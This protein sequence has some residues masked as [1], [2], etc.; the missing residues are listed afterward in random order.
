MAINVNLYIKKDTLV[1]RL[2]GEMDQLTSD[3]LRLKLSELIIKYQV[4]NII[5]NMH[6]LTFLDSSGIGV[7]I[8]R[9]NQI[10]HNNGKIVLCELNEY[11]NKI[12]ELSGLKK[13]CEVKETEELSKF[14]LGVAL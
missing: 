3:D 5:F 12:I 8:G 2:D 13:I 11:I 6:D 10:K 9:Y 4:K 7:I 14:Y 1:C